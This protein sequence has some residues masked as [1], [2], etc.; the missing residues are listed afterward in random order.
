[1][2]RTIMFSIL[3]DLYTSEIWKYLGFK[4][5][6]ACYFLYGLDRFS[7]DL[8]FDLLNEDKHIDTQLLDIVSQ[9]WTVKKWNKIEISYWEKDINI[10]VDINRHIWKANKYEVLNLYGTPIKVQTKDTICANKLVAYY[11]RGTNRDIYDIYFFLKNSY[12]INEWVT[13]ERTWLSLNEL[14]EKIKEKLMSLPQNYKILD[15][16]WEVLGQEQKTFTKN[17][18]INRLI[19]L[20][21]M[22]IQFSKG[23]ND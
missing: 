8:D 15:G 3:Q 2:H 20:I 22:K 7:T 16:L 10:K 9:Y 21:D 5:W 13:L 18:L 1:M 14:L 17:F 12:E 11:E 23:Q 6:T 19:G 4:W